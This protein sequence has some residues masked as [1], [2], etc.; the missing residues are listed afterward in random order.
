M[1]IGVNYPVNCEAV[2]Y[3]GFEEAIAGHSG[4]YLGTL[5]SWCPKEDIQLG[6]N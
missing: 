2:G 6:L 5:G 1:V 4:G 3:K